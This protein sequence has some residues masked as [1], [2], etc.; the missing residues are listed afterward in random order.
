MRMTI[1]GGNPTCRAGLMMSVDRGSPYA[2]GTRNNPERGVTRGRRTIARR[3]V[4][5]EMQISASS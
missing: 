5:T 4:A 3:G 1:N 2:V